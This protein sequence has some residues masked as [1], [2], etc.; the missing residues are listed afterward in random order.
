[1][2]EIETTQDYDR[3]RREEMGRQ[4]PRVDGRDIQPVLPRGRPKPTK[5]A[6]S[7]ETIV[8]VAK[9]LRNYSI[10]EKEEQ[11]EDDKEVSRPNSSILMAKL[12]SLLGQ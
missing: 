11:E 9:W 10:E 6:A 2:G 5:M 7:H 4:D 1:M 12:R 8:N 3:E